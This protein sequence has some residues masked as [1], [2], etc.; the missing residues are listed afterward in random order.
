MRSKKCATKNFSA[1]VSVFFL[2]PPSLSL[3]L[4]L[5]PQPVFLFISPPPPSSF[6]PPPPL[7]TLG[8]LVGS[9]NAIL[10]HPPQ[11]LSLSLFLACPPLFST[12]KRNTEE[13]NQEA[14]FCTWPNQKRRKLT[15][16]KNTRYCQRNKKNFE[17]GIQRKKKQLNRPRFFTQPSPPQPP[18]PPLSVFREENGRRRKN[19]EKKNEGTATKEKKTQKKKATKI[20][21]INIQY[22][23]YR[24]KNTKVAL[25]PQKKNAE[26]TQNN[27]THPRNRPYKK[28]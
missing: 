21:K 4:S 13:K 24:G 22:I 17:V 28:K 11:S 2:V 20:A 15:T 8:E 5:S 6:H 19:E 3:S 12:L 10:S 16:T 25:S 26:H 7:F 1:D 27:S 23:F 18:S 14:I 9:Q